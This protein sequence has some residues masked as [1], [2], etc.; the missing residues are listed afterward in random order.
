MTMAKRANL[1][2]LLV[3]SVLFVAVHCATAAPRTIIV[4][5]DGPADY[6]SIQAAIND[7][8]DGD[9]VLVSEGH[10]FENIDFR[11]KAITVASTNPDDPNV[12]ADTII[13]ANGDGIVVSFHMGEAPNSVIDGFTITGGNAQYGAGVTCW[14]NSSPAIINCTI[15]AN[16]A[17]GSGGG[18][19]CYNSSPAVSYCTISDNSAAFG[20][21]MANNNS[22]PTLANCTFSGNSAYSGGGMANWN[23]SGPT[24]NECTFS[25]NLGGR[26]GA[27]YSSNSSPTLSKCTFSVNSA[28]D[29]GGG[30]YN[31]HF[32]SPTLT[33]CTFSGNSAY[34][35]GGIY[36]ENNS[37]PKVTSC[38]FSVNSAAPGSGGGICNRHNSSPTVTTSTFSQNTAGGFGGAMSNYNCSG[39]TV[40]SCVFTA[41]YS[42]NSAGF[43]GGAIE[44]CYYTSA[45]LTNCTFSGNSAKRGGGIYNHNHSDQTLTNCTFTGNTAEQGGAIC[46]DWYA[47]DLLTNCILWSDEPNEIFNRSASTTTVT[48]SDV[49][50]AW[51]GPGN[52]DV[53]PCFADPCNGDFHLKS[54][55]GRW[56]PNSESWVLDDV[57]SPCIDTGDP[58][59]SFAAELS[60]HGCR[61]N[62][63]A[64]GN[65][66]QASKSPVM[67][68]VCCESYECAGQ[69]FGDATCDGN[70]NFAD[71][72]ALKAHYGTSAPWA[73][74]QCCAD[75]SHD[76]NVN[77][78]DLFTLKAGFGT[79]GYSPSTG[80]QDCASSLDP[81]M[82]FIP[83]GECLMGDHF[84]EGGP[85]ELPVHAVYV[86]SFHMG[87]YEITNQ[88]YC[89]Y[90]NSAYP[91]QIKVH[92]GL[93]YASYDSGNSCPYCD[94]H[95]SDTDSQIDYND[96]SGT[97]SVRT[98]GEP[99]RDMSDDPIVEVSWYGSVAYCNWRSAQEGYQQLYDPC[100]P[101]WP[102]DF[103]KHGYRLPTEGEWE[104]AAR[105]GLSGRRFPWADP[106]ITHSQ[107]NYRANPSFYPYDVSPTSGYHPDWYDGVEPYTSVVGSFSANGYGLYDMAGNVWEWCNDWYASGYYN[108]SPYD[109]PQGPASSPYRVLRGGGCGWS[110]SA[111]YC[112]VAARG[113]DRPQYGGYTSGFRVVL[114][115]SD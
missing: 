25:G 101:N 65:T 49:Q 43:G 14:G 39:L 23:G 78:D 108:A 68:S 34:N 13:D 51:P 9:T 50:G 93:V 105:G 20:G 2:T 64:Y 66:E 85:D 36:N 80:N 115:L 12:V 83:G 55:G 27:I 107:A 70:V 67:A 92:G 5:D 110:G 75:F 29:D 60:P 90:L 37:S 41:N 88:Q 100:N 72:F 45:L 26:G 7:A 111:L 63:G 18:V 3:V 61:V 47:S 112:R 94:T 58:C 82:V 32:S 113:L 103:S 21:G 28:D 11:G 38:T 62:M 89:D 59:T 44:S 98:K 33:N 35:G 84:N 79:S 54:E 8:N 77:L 1:T 40:T 114:D 104:Y 42:A 17:A 6:S 4:D 81:D 46:N 52:I 53:D 95:S 106:N 76:G 91:A 56:D 31:Y 96:V 10:Y 19:Y 57:T 99:P 24:M 16:L 69:P 74:D 71:L 87:R 86:D 102:C 73:D 97:F 109:N 22:S 30:M 48:Y 15:N